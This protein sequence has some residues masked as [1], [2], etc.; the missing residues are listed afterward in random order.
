MVNVR[1]RKTI[2]VEMQTVK[3]LD[4]LEKRAHRFEMRL[5]SLEF[6]ALQQEAKEADTSIAEIIRSRLWPK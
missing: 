1:I 6:L 4:N 5:T 3:Y 2:K